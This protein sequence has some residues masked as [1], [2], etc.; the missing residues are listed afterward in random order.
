VCLDSLRLGGGLCVE[1]MIFLLGEADVFGQSFQF[2]GDGS[3]IQVAAATPSERCGEQQGH[4]V[5]GCPNLF[6]QVVRRKRLLD[7]LSAMHRAHG[8]SQQA[9]HVEAE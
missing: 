4:T 2:A 1:R 5:P 9:Q 6:G 8:G 3:I 7:L